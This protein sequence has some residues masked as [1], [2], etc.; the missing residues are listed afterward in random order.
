MGTLLWVAL[1][2]VLA[3]L[4]VFGSCAIYVAHKARQLATHVR[5]EIPRVQR[6]LDEKTRAAMEASDVCALVTPAELEEIYGTPFS[7]GEHQPG[8]HEGAGCTYTKT[9]RSQPSVTIVIDRSMTRYDQ[10]L[11]RARHPYVQEDIGEA[12]AYF[13]N[14]NT[15]RLGYRWNYV[16]IAAEGGRAK[17]EQVARALLKRL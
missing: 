15:M 6:Q 8:E 1:G 17:C 5:A 9:G 14:P 12:K 13:V 7:P 16:E 11:K 10:E 3:L 2:I 4:L